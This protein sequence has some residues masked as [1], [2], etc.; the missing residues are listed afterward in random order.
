MLID[1]IGGS[2]GTTP[3]QLQ[4]RNPQGT[5]QTNLQAGYQTSDITL[6]LPAALPTTNGQV[7]TANTTGAMQWTDLT[8]TSWSVTGNAGTNP[9]T[10]FLGTTDA[11]D[12]VL[13]RDN[14]ERA[15]LTN[16]GLRVTQNGT[17]RTSVWTMSVQNIVGTGTPS[18]TVV[19]FL[20]STRLARM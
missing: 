12:L 11:N 3:G 6:T 8:S 2:G 16:A 18:S 9:S 13:R 10:N 20:N 5:A 14:T 19:E 15:R 17:P 4:L 7:L 1:T